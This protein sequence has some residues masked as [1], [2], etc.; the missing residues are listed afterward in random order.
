[1][2]LLFRHFWHVDVSV[3]LCMV[4]FITM[5]G[6]RRDT[7]FNSESMVSSINMCKK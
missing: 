4:L 2:K 6:I 3:V 1:M 7:G 5:T